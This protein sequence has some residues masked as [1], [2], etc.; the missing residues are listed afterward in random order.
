MVEF[1]CMFLIRVFHVLV[2]LLLVFAAWQVSIQKP[3][4]CPSGLLKSSLFVLGVVGL[5]AA[6]YHGWRIFQPGFVCA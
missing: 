3:G 1:D 5:G 2:G 4:E 6:V